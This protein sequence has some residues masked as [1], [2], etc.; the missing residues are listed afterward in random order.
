MASFNHTN[1]L[2]AIKKCE[3]ERKRAIQ[4]QCAAFLCKNQKTIENLTN[5]CRLVSCAY[6]T[7][8]DNNDFDGEL[9]SGGVSH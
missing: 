2:E 3:R 7:V 5:V 1:W 4:D 9:C 6:E 8:V